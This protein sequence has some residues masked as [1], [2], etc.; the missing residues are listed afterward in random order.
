M[1]HLSI[2]INYR[3]KTLR[4][5]KSRHWLSC[6]YKFVYTDF[7][8]PVGV[9][10]ENSNICQMQL[11]GEKQKIH[12][13]T[14]LVR[15]LRKQKLLPLSLWKCIKLRNLKTLRPHVWL[16]RK[17]KFYTHIYS[18]S[19]VWTNFSNNVFNKTLMIRLI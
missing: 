2:I 12:K 5:K 15:Y 17:F 14:F 18:S 8:R 10:F 9:M 13:P 11:S 7:G 16:N 3:N 4:K 1:Y 6:M 19:L